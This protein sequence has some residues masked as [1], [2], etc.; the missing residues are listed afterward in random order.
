MS[1]DPDTSQLSNCSATGQANR[2]FGFLDG[3]L[4]WRGIGSALSAATIVI[5][6]DNDKTTW[7]ATRLR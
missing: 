1:T 3:A 2:Q 7:L 6:E 4:I 5:S